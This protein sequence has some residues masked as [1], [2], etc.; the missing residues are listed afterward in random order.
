VF[1]NIF[2]NFYQVRSLC[3]ID[4]WLS[5]WTSVT[6]VKKMS[7]IAYFKAGIRLEELKRKM[8]SWVE[9]HRDSNEM[10]SKYELGAVAIS[11]VHSVPLKFFRSVHSVPVKLFRS[12]HS[13]PLKFFRSLHS[14]PIK[15]FRSVHS[16]PLKFFS[17]V[18]SVPVKSFTSVHSVLVKFMS[19]QSFP[20]NFFRRIL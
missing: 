6:G 3:A 4:M 13:V 9:T 18:H 8:N 16:V 11:S 5:L 2:K 20:V 19:L 7:V 17:S 10:S 1:C 12:V 15:S 14:V